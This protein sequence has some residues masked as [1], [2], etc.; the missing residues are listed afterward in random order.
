MVWNPLTVDSRDNSRY[1]RSLSDLFDAG[2]DQFDYKYYTWVEYLLW[3][4]K[5]QMMKIEFND[6]QITPAPA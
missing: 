5:T 1:P 3:C 6:I 2:F 4:C